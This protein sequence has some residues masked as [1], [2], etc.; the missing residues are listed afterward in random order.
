MLTHTDL[1]ALVICYGFLLQAV[2]YHN[3]LMQ[4]RFV[5]LCADLADKTWR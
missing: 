4:V 5:N 3:L 2:E 1:E